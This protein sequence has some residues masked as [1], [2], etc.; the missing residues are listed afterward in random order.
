MVHYIQTN[1]T[2]ASIQAFSA[3]WYDIALDENL[4]EN[5]QGLLFFPPILWQMKILSEKNFQELNQ[6]NETILQP[7]M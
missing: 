2:I 6:E 5:S 4:Y 3:S 1:Q 7:V